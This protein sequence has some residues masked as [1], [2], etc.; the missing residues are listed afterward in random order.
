MHRKIKEKRKNLKPLIITSNGAIFKCHYCQGIVSENYITK[1]HLKAKSDGGANH[2]SNYM[3]SCFDCNWLKA[4]IPYEKFMSVIKEFGLELTRVETQEGSF[5]H[6]IAEGGL[7]YY[8]PNGKPKSQVNDK[9]GFGSR[10]LTT[11]TVK[12]KL[13]LFISLKKNGHEQ[14]NPEN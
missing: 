13:Y 9:I 14:P 12:T 5:N 1:D 8:L 11:V 10:I 3:P 7:F 6:T 4:D 2:P